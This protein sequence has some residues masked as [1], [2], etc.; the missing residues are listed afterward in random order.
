MT[1]AE[2]SHREG[3]ASFKVGQGFYRRTSQVGRDLAILAAQLEKG[4]RGQLRV[5]DSMA[6][7]GV[8]SLRY[9]LEGG[10][11]WVLANEGNPEMNGIL[12]ENLGPML[13]AQAGEIQHRDANRVFFQCYDRRDYYDLVD[14]DSFGSPV[15]FLNTS[16][17][18]VRLGGLVYLTSTDGRTATGHEREQ[19]L[20]VYGAYG[21]SHPSGHEQGLRLLIGSTQQQA[22]SKGL[23]VEPLFSLYA[24]SVYRVMLRLVSG[25]QL[26]EANYGFLA[27]CHD[28]GEYETVTWR[29]LGRIS[30]CSRDGQSRVLS[31]PLWLG[32]LHDRQYLHRMQTLA[33]Q[34]GWPS[35][36]KLLQTMIAEADL[37]PYFYG[38][39]EIGRRSGRDMLP[40]EQLLARLRA[41]GYRSSATHITPQAVKTEADLATC[42]AIA[43][44]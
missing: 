43:R 26:T 29:Q 4:D 5:L 31:G 11:D 25:Q 14:V 41:R 23:G 15:P 44:E 12:Q 19:S 27:Y 2:M 13:A 24:H 40:R 6:G 39:G 22:A 1:E 10:A 18:A 38:L 36:V 17:W 9:W 37:P 33:Q 30:P 35:R 34:Q 28:C 16:L 3:G 8:R 32:A 7:C 20:R 42:V 21:R